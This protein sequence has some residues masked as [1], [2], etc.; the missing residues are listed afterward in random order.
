MRPNKIILDVEP[1][2][3]E[4]FTKIAMMEVV[5]VDPVELL[6]HAIIAVQE[7]DHIDKKV[8]QFIRSYSTW[9]SV[10]G[11]VTEDGK[12]LTA[13][14]QALTKDIESTYQTMA[15]WDDNNVSPYVFDRLVGETVMI[16]KMLDHA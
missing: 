11:E 10:N 2:V 6:S 7:K 3:R 4:L 16:S 9:G 13:A 14:W 5:E 1:A 8:A 12:I 15:L